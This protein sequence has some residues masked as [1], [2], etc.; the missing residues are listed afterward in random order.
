[1]LAVTKLHLFAVHIIQDMML[2]QYS[3]ND[4]KKFDT[5]EVHSCEFPLTFSDNKKFFKMM[6]F[7]AFLLHDLQEQKGIF[8]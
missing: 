5:I 7:F 4:N 8:D 3:Y 1:V 6:E 2:T